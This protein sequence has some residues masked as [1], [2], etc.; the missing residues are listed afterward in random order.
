ME[1]INKYW[2][3]LLV[4]FGVRKFKTTD[5]G[6]MDFFLTDFVNSRQKN[7]VVA[8]VKRCGTNMTKCKK[9]RR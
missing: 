3:L 2:H 7:P 1:L 9:I 6:L 5:E 8:R 4:F